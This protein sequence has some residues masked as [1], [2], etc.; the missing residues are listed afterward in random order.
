[1]KHGIKTITFF[2]ILSF[3]PL[4]VSAETITLS[5]YYPAPYGA[6]DRLKLVPRTALPATCEPGS[7]FA[8]SDDDNALKYCK[9]RDGD[10]TPEWGSM[11]G[12]WDRDGETIFLDDAVI[13]TGLK[14]GIGDSTP[15]AVLEVVAFNGEHP[16]MVSS[17][18][19]SSGDYMIIKPTGRVGVGN[20][21]PSSKLTVKGVGIGTTASSTLNVTNGADTSMFYVRDDGRVKV[22][23]TVDMDNEFEVA[24]SIETE[25][26]GTSQIRFQNT[27]TGDWYSLGIDAADGNLFKINFGS[28][29]GETDSFIMDQNGNVIITG[30]LTIDDGLQE[31]TVQVQ[32][33]NDATQPGY[34]ATYAP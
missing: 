13:G 30:S 19:T 10:L 20:T 24:G 33:V 9:D 26:A 7:F 25:V 3:I 11:E 31:G 23:G 2:A 21:A 15:S 18:N 22:G 17:D 27:A 34:Y 32:F 5:T 4:G 29:V 16:L 14:V 6:Y 12:V 1:M 8:S 28:V